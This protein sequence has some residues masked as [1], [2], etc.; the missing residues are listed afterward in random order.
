MHNCVCEREREVAPVCE[1][2]LIMHKLS[3]RKFA[4]LN[5]DKVNGI[6]MPKRERETER[7]KERVRGSCKELVV[8]VSPVK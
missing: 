2:V 6:I 5:S 8:A 3:L 7:S 1:S 4:A